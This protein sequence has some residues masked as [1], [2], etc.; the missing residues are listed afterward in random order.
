VSRFLWIVYS[1]LQS[2][3]PLSICWKSATAQTSTPNVWCETRR[4]LLNGLID[5]YLYHSGRIDMALAFEELRS[6]SLIKGAAK[7][8]DSAS[9]A[10]S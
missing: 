7:A 10:N 2:S 4:H 6:R 9:D 8:A 1:N 5:S 3:F